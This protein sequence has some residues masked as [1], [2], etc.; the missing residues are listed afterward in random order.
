MEVKK[1]GSLSASKKANEEEAQVRK[2]KYIGEE[3]ESSSE[4]E[5]DSECEEDSEDEE[6]ET[7]TIP[8][9]LIQQV[10]QGRN[11]LSRFMIDL[12]KRIES[13]SIHEESTR[14]MK[15]LQDEELGVKENSQ[16]KNLKKA[17]QQALSSNTTTK[18]T[19]KLKTPSTSEESRTSLELESTLSS[20]TSTLK[21]LVN[22]MNL[23]QTQIHK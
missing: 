19:K 2:R 3:D 11:R 15:Q 22:E 21:H 1:R 12:E 18:S 17:K 20:I 5:E 8:K 13:G 14:Y 10:K 16:P 6:E 7:N 9:E 4:S 23:L